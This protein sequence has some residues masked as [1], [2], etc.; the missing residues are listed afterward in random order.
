MRSRPGIALLV[1]FAACALPPS[2]AAAGATT[3][4]LDDLGDSSFEEGRALGVDARGGAVAAWMRWPDEDAIFVSIRRPGQPFG[5]RTKLI[6][7]SAPPNG[8]TL[9]VGA[10]G[11]GA[12]VWHDAG[13]N[14]VIANPNSVLR[15]NRRLPGKGFGSP[16][17]LPQTR[18]IEQSAAAI[19]GRGRLV[20]AWRA[21]SGRAG[22]GRVV[23]AITAPRNAPFGSPRQLSGDC[24]N[25]DDLRVAVGRGGAGAVAWRAKVAGGQ[26][27]E[28]SMLRDGHFAAA[29]TASPGRVQAG[30][31]VALAAGGNHALLAWRDHPTPGSTSGRVLAASIDAGEIHPPLPV[32]A[33]AAIRD[34]VGAAMNERGAAIIGWLQGPPTGETFIGPSR[35]ALRPSASTPFGP[36]E[37]VSE[38]V[39]F[40]APLLA[41]DGAAG[42]FALS[43]SALQRHASGIWKPVPGRPP[44][45]TNTDVAVGCSD[46]GEAIF[47]T[48]RATPQE[49]SLLQ[50]T[51]V[52]ARGSTA[53]S[54]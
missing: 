9:A 11:D 15:V 30:G 21:R 50:V 46:A 41:L 26:I 3:Q 48:L 14:P 28:V 7:G 39:E 44:V 4:T 53:S 20:I 51:I 40:G 24:P 12:I 27:V 34:H 37:T 8:L 2:A 19:D 35:V 18:G 1:A 32:S 49:T 43:D 33:S 42:A 47:A 22:C 54:R 29:R 45:D 31:G 13:P 36:G 38:S 25:A 52:P 10:R 23:M 16:I 5:A 17:V 6:T